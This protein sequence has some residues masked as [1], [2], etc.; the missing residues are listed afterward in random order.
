MDDPLAVR[1]RLLA[2]HDLDVVGEG[3]G[4]DREG[5]VTLSG[6]AA[7][8]G[9]V[10]VRTAV[11]VTAGAGHGP[12]AVG[13]ATAGIDEGSGTRVVGDTGLQVRH[14]LE[15]AVRPRLRPRG[16]GGHGNGAAGQRQGSCDHDGLAQHVDLSWSR[17]LGQGGCSR[18]FHPKVPLIHRA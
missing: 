17:P 12:L 3:L 15:S 9:G 6:P 2:E 1:R 11:G 16:D 10:A 13:G 4:A 14:V 8:A 18:V 5:R 7:L